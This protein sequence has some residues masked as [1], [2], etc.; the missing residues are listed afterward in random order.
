MKI[1]FMD[2]LGVA[3]LENIDDVFGH[4]RCTGNH[5]TA[6]FKMKPDGRGLSPFRQQGTGTRNFNA[7]LL[8]VN[9]DEYD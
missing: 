6:G 1:H 7:E 3:A 2:V 4:K 8:Q 5:S 9:S